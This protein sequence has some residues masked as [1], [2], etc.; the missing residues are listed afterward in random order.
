MVEV[1]LNYGQ[2]KIVGLNPNECIIGGWDKI[3]GL[4]VNEGIKLVDADGIILCLDY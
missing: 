4:D 3:I 1:R 2:I